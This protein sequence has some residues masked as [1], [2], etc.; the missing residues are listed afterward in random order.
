M[1]AARKSF[2]HRH[3]K[4]RRTAEES[5]THNKF[6]ATHRNHF[7]EA[8]CFRPNKHLSLMWICSPIQLVLANFHLVLACHAHQHKHRE[9]IISGSIIPINVLF[10]ARSDSPEHCCAYASI[11]QINIANALFHIKIILVFCDSHTRHNTRT[12]WEKRLAHTARRHTHTLHRSHR[13]TIA[14]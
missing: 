4:Y 6:S 9:Q 8:H 10:Y 1:W 2:G 14:E 12:A 5:N 13:P 11:F 3:R 7:A